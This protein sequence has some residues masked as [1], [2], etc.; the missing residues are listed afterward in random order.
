MSN[1]ITII[2]QSVK[3]IYPQ[4]V[5]WRRHLHQYPELSGQEFKTANF[6]YQ[7][8]IELNCFELQRPTET[9]VIAI[10]KSHRPGKT[11]ALRADIDALP[12][13]EESDSQFKSQHPGIMHACAHDGHT[14]ALLGIACI[15]AQYQHLITGTIKLIFQHAEEI[16]TGALELIEHGVLEGL[17]YLFGA[18][19]WSPL[20]LGK[21]GICYGPMMAA[22]DFFTITITGK[23]GHAAI[24]QEAIDPVIIGAEL[25][26][27]LQTIISRKI[28]PIR[29][30]LISVTR[31]LSDS[32]YNVIPEKVTLG[33]TLRSLDM[34]TMNQIYDE[35]EKLSIQIA[36]MHSATATVC[37]EQRHNSAPLY[38]NPDATKLVEEALTE[39]MGAKH[40]QYTDPTL[41]GE[42]FSQY[43]K[44]G[45]PACFLFI[46]TRS[47][48]ADYPHHH[49]KFNIN[50]ESMQY[51]MKAFLNIIR[52]IM[53]E[54]K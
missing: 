24:P 25:V 7:I 13:Q 42:D 35:I 5:Q 39:G 34:E 29:T 30:G 18:H 12:V 44:Q 46:G 16:G 47:P 32:A 28:N 17:D 3:Q 36:H 54:E 40:C 6:I 31:F 10:L 22:G 50:E 49:A 20:E 45:I 33:G 41:A 51:S 9:S 52:K 4:V 37:F 8:L 15:L 11:I 26:L 43:T 23:S 2:N 38:N 19:I 21:I 48:G 27:A 14:A 53:I 1:F